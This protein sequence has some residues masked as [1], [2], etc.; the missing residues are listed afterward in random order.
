MLWR[1]HLAI[2]KHWTKTS[3]DVLAVAH[4]LTHKNAPTEFFV[5]TDRAV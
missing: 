4:P 5:L 2:I 3:D 1:S